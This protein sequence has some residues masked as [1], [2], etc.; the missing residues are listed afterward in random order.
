MSVLA[1]VFILGWLVVI[2][3]SKISS[4]AGVLEK[5]K[6]ITIPQNGTHVTVNLEKTLLDKAGIKITIIN[7]A[8]MESTWKSY[9][10][11]SIPIKTSLPE[12]FTVSYSPESQSLGAEVSGAKDYVDISVFLMNDPENLG[13][14]LFNIP[15]SEWVGIPVLR[16]HYVNLFELSRSKEV[17]LSDNRKINIIE[18]KYKRLLAIY[19]PTSGKF[20]YYIRLENR[21]SEGVDEIGIELAEKFI[22]KVAEN[23]QITD[24]T[25]EE[26][27]KYYSV[28][29]QAK[30]ITN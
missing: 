27:S 8:L 1:V 28:E 13:H 19:L 12:Q 11:V 6:I 10:P 16:R 24:L 23:T 25:Q 29:E 5:G 26:Y 17:V 30:R 2:A 3:A 14:I 21:T 7:D 15:E 20:G 4:E 18:D 22:T 9:A